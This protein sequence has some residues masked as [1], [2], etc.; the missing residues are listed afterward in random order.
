MLDRRGQSIRPEF[1]ILEIG[2]CQGDIQDLNINSDIDLYRIQRRDKINI[3][4]TE[5]LRLTRVDD[6]D[7]GGG[8]SL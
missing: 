8:Y 5:Q 4:N 6:D 3:T 2:I 1:G 7:S